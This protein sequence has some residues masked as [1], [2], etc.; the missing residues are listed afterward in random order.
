M[1]PQ[2]LVLKI[3]F[4]VS[5]FSILYPQIVI[6]NNCHQKTLLLKQKKEIIDLDGSAWEV[7][8][9]NP[10]SRNYSIKGLKLDAKINQIVELAD[11]ICQ[12]IK[13]VPLNELATY[14]LGELKSQG[15]INFKNQLRE[16]G[17]PEAEIDI[18]FL[19]SKIASKFDG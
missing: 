18:W 10:E 8:E 2:Y 9:K 13:G 19:Y 7:F 11:Y 1:S 4:I 5:F 6:G 15:I 14:V 3:I 16:F 17:K 12:T